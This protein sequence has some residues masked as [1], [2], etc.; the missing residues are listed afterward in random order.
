VGSSLESG[1]SRHGEAARPEAVTLRIT[2]RTPD[3]GDQGDEQH[4][5]HTTLPLL[6]MEFGG[7]LV[8]QFEASSPMDAGLPRL[9]LQDDIIASGRYPSAQVLRLMVGRALAT[10]LM[11]DILLEEAEAEILA[12]GISVRCWQEGLLRQV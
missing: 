12:R 4:F 5:L 3:R 2:C 1:V 11:M 8:V 9:V 6:E 7:H 10:E